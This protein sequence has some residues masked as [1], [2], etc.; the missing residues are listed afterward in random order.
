MTSQQPKGKREMAEPTRLWRVAFGETRDKRV[1]RLWRVSSVIKIPFV[2]IVLL[3][4]L[5]VKQVLNWHHL[6]NVLLCT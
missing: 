2:L 1:I 5:I 3:L 6:I 4:T